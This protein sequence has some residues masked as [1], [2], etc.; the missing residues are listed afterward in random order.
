MPRHRSDEDLRERIL[1]AC[2]AQLVAGPAAVTVRE[3]AARAGVS[4]GTLYHYFASSDDLLLA[5]AARAASRQRETF[6]DP[7]RGVAAVL[8][9]LFDATRRD[10]VLPWLR[11]RAI[12]SPDLAA[13]LQRYDHDVNAAYTTAIRD[14][15]SSIGLADAVDIEAAVEVIRALAEGFQLRVASSTLAIEP[16]RF[17]ASVVDAVLTTWF[18]APGADP[19][20]P[21]TQVGRMSTRPDTSRRRSIPSRT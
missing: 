13:A 12:A 21:S 11:Q 17:T 1:D 10:T 16:A 20:S 2:E 3:V 19:A 15:A 14:A 8:Q 4:N 18:N 6:G 9:R 5:V 7:S